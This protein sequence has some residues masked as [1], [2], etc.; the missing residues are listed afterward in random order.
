MTT[1]IT[2]ATCHPLPKPDQDEAPLVRALVERGLSVRVCPWHDD[3]VDWSAS[4]VTLIRSTWNYYHDRPGFVRWAEHVDDVSSLFNSA[5][6]VRWNSHKRYLVELARA[7]VPTVPTVLAE[8]GTGVALDALCAARGWRRVV[9]KPAVSAGSFET[10]I[11]DVEKGDDPAFARLA[12]ER[13]VLVQPYVDAV[14]TYG[15]RSL[16]VIDG[17]LT[18]SVKKHPR[19]A[20]QEE[21][22]TGPHP[23]APAERELAE[24]ALAHVDAPLLY[25]RVDMV[26]AAD[27]Q[28]ML[29]ELELIE[30]SLFF[31]FGQ[32]ALER[33]VD[34]LEERC[35]T[36]RAR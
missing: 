20:G 29:T 30:P 18:H 9:V 11:V 24:A 27:G 16:I 3:E 14:D 17:E 2:L 32:P 8:R 33:L 4:P 22:T 12:A 25:A 1:D 19:F 23:I 35:R 7:G 15:E 34:A 13:D 31:R 5:E 26:P 36:L 28:P 6:I 21:H 10:H